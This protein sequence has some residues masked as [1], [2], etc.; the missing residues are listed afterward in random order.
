VKTLLESGANANATCKRGWSPLKH[1]A[2][3]GQVQLIDVLVSYDASLKYKSVN[4]NTVLHFVCG[5]AKELRSYEFAV[6][7]LELGANI[8]AA[9]PG[10]YTALHEATI[11]NDFKMV[12]MLVQRGANIHTTTISAETP[13]D[14]AIREEHEEIRDFLVSQSSPD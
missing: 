12:K 10:N 14:I 7:L 3:G 2:D 4:G 6:R 11:A 8:D 1:A 13:L 9:G 5:G